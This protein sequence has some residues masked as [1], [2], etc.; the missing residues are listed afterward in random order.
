MTYQCGPISGHVEDVTTDATPK[1]LVLFAG[2]PSSSINGRLRVTARRPSDGATKCWDLAA[3]MRMDANSVA[4]NLA[5]VGATAFGASGDLTTLL[6]VTITF[7]NS[8]ADIGLT[9]T[10]LAGSTIEWCADFNGHQL[11][12]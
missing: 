7:F 6:L 12:D 4:S 11:V 3:A 5:N 10:G 1:N 9:V 2:N 8:G